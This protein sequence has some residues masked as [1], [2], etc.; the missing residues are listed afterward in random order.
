M[1]APCLL[2]ETVR[3]SFFLYLQWPHGFVFDLKTPASVIKT[4][5]SP[6]FGNFRKKLLTNQSVYTIFDRPLIIR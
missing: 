1:D 6:I 2:Q 3:L 4:N 5:F